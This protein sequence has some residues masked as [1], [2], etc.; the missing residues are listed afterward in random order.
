[1][2][3]NTIHRKVMKTLER[4]IEEDNMDFDET[5]ESAV[6]KRKFL[7]NRLMEKKLLPDE[8]DDDKEAEEEVEA[9]V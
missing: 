3:L 4:I 9:S 6:E 8:S 2:K 7:L 1:M 5:A